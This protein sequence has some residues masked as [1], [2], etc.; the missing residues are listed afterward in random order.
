MHQ[1]QTIGLTGYIRLSGND[2]Q[3]NG[4]MDYQA[5]GQMDKG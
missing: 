5:N 2:Y 4:L 1:S 3:T